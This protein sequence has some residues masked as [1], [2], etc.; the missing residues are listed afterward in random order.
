MTRMLIV[1]ASAGEQLSVVSGIGV[2]IGE[3]LFEG[4]SWTMGVVL[5]V[6]VGVG[7]LSC[8]C[9]V[10]DPHLPTG[11]VHVTREPGRDTLV[12]LLRRIAIMSENQTRYSGDNRVWSEFYD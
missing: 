6:T 5:L 2:T 11:N 7:L 9:T 12:Q 4:R 1:G 10:F 3:D 8:L